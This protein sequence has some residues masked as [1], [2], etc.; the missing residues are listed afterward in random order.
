MHRLTTDTP[1]MLKNLFRNP[2]RYYTVQATFS[3][4]ELEL[5]HAFFVERNIER[6]IE[7]DPLLDDLSA[8]LSTLLAE[9]KKRAKKKARVTKKS[10]KNKVEKRVENR[11]TEQDHEQGFSGE[12]MMEG[13]EQDDLPTPPTP[14]LSLPVLPVLPPLPVL[15]YSDVTEAVVSGGALR[16][17]RFTCLSNT[18][19]VMKRQ[20]EVAARS[21]GYGGNWVN[22]GTGGMGRMGRSGAEGIEG[23]GEG[24]DGDGGAGGAEGAGGTGEAVGGDGLHGLR[25]AMWRFDLYWASFF[26]EVSILVAMIESFIDFEQYVLE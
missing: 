8:D 22:G 6:N 15:L 9:A 3:T 4:Y 12:E 24:V 26:E 18:P 25:E 13:K 1:T 19:P 2:L 16:P 14:P 11:G 21:R 10:V 23:M 20:R 7:D 17:P 5:E